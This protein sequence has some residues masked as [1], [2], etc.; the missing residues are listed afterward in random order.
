VKT[1]NKLNMTNRRF[2]LGVVFFTALMDSIGFGIILPVTPTLLM[3]V[4]DKGLSSSAV[5]GGW[6]MFSFA[7]MQFISMPVLGNLSDAYGRKPV[8]LGSLLVLS[9]NYLIMGLAQSLVL[10]FIGRMISGVGSATFSTCNAYIA[11]TTSIDERAQFFGLMGAAFG[12]GF[13]IGPVLGGFLG[14][15]GS[16]VPFFATAGLIFFNLLVGLIFLPE[17]HTPNNRRPFEI[18]RANP[19]SAMKQMSQFKIAFGIIGVLFLY[20]MGHH[21]LPAVWTFWGIEKFDW[22]PR[23]IGYSLGFI[24]ILMVFSQGYLIR[25]VIPALGMRWA[26]LVGLSFTITAFLGY[27]LSQTPTMAYMFMIAG[28]LGGLAGPAMSGIASSQVGPAQQ[29]EL[30]GAIG[31]VGSLTNIISPLMMTIVFGIYTAPDAPFYF[32]GAP[33]ILAAILTMMS[34]SLFFWITIGFVQKAA[35]DPS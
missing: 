24:G 23:E 1:E 27:A 25:I 7:I 18:R 13:V 21:A 8:L 16:R 2:A 11:D 14:E 32:P 19:F 31:S 10:L 26:G 35:E 20:N 5:Y 15:Y 9:I 34:L 6:L 12:L 3:E 17:S 22:T 28:A 33:F 29:G 4:S 30:Q